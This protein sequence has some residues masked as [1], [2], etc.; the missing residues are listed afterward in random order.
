MTVSHPPRRPIVEMLSI[1]LPTVA[2]MASYTV[3]QFIDT[4]MLS[5]LGEAAAT[6]ASNSGILAFS[7]IGFGVGTLVLV[8]ALVSQNFGRGQFNQCGQ[9]MWQGVWI[10]LGYG[11]MLLL[12]CPAGAPIF[13]AFHHPLDQV[14]MEATYWRIVLLT[15]A[16]KLMATAVG[17]FLLGIDRPNCILISAIIGVSINAVCAWAIVL[18]HLG[19]RSFGI[20]GAAWAQ[21]IGV[22]CEFLTLIFFTARVPAQFGAR[23]AMLRLSQAWALIKV[24]APS[25]LQWLSDILAWSV[26][27][28]GVMGVL[29][30][31][32]MAANTFTFRYI[33]VSFMPAVGFQAAVTALVGRY[34]GRGL[35]DVAARR[36]HLA[37]GL[38][39][40][41]M[42][43]CC[44][45]F[46]VARHSLI[47]VFTTR[48]QIARVGELYLTVAAVYELFD[49][50]YIIYTGALRGAGDTLV[51][52]VVMAF[53]CWSIMV[54]GGYL[55]ALYVPQLGLAGPWM[56]ACLYGMI[57]GIYVMRRFIGGKWRN[58]QLGF[59]DRGENPDKIPAQWSAA[60]SSSTE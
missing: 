3:M 7:F 12:L 9:Y 27:S 49:A 16:I 26:F 50:M 60:P 41:Y 20:A 44:T 42:V 55:T 43:I 15:S 4:W 40:V 1:A 28:N 24:G 8:N 53:L 52:T 30:P 39:T 2:Q 31:D 56:V 38:T 18:G 34:I 59:I 58:I 46:V 35:P 57:L 37:F 23:D 54:G 17:Q 48:P 11:V 13:R 33:V 45:I 5:R 29:G 36:A 21:N 51:P 19:F 10:G 25:G 6:A 32:S 22:C 47:G 14:A